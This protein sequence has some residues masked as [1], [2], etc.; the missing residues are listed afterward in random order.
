MS[1]IVYKD[2]LAK[3]MAAG[4][5]GYRVLHDGQA[6]KFKK[7]EQRLGTFSDKRSYFWLYSSFNMNI[8]DSPDRA[9]QLFS[10]AF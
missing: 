2:L 4:E 6:A 9:T 5:P 7:K 8:N 1:L 3:V 10:Q